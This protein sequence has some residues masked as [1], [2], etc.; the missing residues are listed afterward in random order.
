MILLYSLSAYSW[1]KEHFIQHEFYR[2]S[3]FITWQDA[4]NITDASHIIMKLPL[5]LE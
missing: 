2:F 5:F 4:L 3:L 1:H